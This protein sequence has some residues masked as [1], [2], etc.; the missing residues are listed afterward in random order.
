MLRTDNGTQF[1]SEEFSN[2]AR[3]YNFTR[4][5]SSPYF[6]QAN[7]IAENSVKQAKRILEQPDVY[8]ALMEHRTSPTTVTG[9]SPCQLLQ[10]SR[11]QATLP[12]TEQKLKP[13]WPAYEIL[14]L[15]HD[16]SKDNQTQNYNIAHGA[17][18][19]KP[20]RFWRRHENEKPP[21]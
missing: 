11:M 9:Y 15:N 19:L 2:F 1:V 3:D 21:R 5:T 20:L 13:K 18:E 8:L 16:R 17:K 12:I 10:G 4:E 14:Q 6:A 7:G